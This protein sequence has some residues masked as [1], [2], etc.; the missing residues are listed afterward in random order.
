MFSINNREASMAYTLV[1]Y[2]AKPERAD[3]NE[4]LIAGVF[5][6]LHAEGP[7]DLRYMALRLEDDT[8]IH[9]VATESED[10]TLRSLASF[11]AFQQDIDERQIGPPQFRTAAL[12]GNYRMLE[13]LAK[14]VSK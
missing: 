12:V 5:R 1:N 3:E 9:L 10:P 11:Q 13:S 4:R 14:A 7:A 6:E 2:K 8:F